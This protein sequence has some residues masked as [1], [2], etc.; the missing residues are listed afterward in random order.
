VRWVSKFTLLFLVLPLTVCLAQD[1]P[2]TRDLT[3]HTFPETE[4]YLETP[5]GLKRVGESGSRFSVK[6]EKSVNSSGKVTGYQGGFLILRATGHVDYRMS[7]SAQDWNQPRLPRTGAYLL[8]PSSP[9]TELPETVEITINTFPETG[10]FLITEEGEKEVGKSGKAFSMKPPV[11]LN[12]ASNAY[13]YVPGM[14]ILRAP[15]HADYR[16]SVSTEDWKEPTLPRSGNYNLT[17]DSL[18]VAI[19]DYIQAYPYLAALALLSVFGLLAFFVVPWSVLRLRRVAKSMDSMTEQLNSEGDPLVGKSLGKY[20]VN[21]RLG[22]GG[23]GTVYR[24]SDDIGDYAAK[25]IY[26]DK[27]DTQEL[28]RFRREFRLLSQMQHPVFPRAYDYREEEGRAFAVMELI[29]GE[30]LR[31]RVKPEGLPWA[32]VRDW[33]RSLLEGL[34]C[35]HQEGVVHRDLKPENLMLADDQIRILDFGLARQGSGPAITRTGQAFG[36]PKYIAPEQLFATGTETE[37]RS[38]LYSLGIIAYELITGTTPF[39]ADDPKVLVVMHLNQEPEPID[40]ALY[41][42]PPGVN[43]FVMTL[44]QKN[45]AN[46]YLDA[47]S[48]LRTLKNI[49]EP[50]VQED[51]MAVQMPEMD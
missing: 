2:D 4:I 5:A 33:L 46:R 1:F 45:P 39:E 9:P 25:V 6:P 48:A 38:D 44:L 14:L 51:T 28:A 16:M 7:V 20:R 40:E 17:P 35:A 42:L 50:V 27:T 32:T 29:N 43:E 49:D 21:E 23:V 8:S 26:L 31:K 15:D 10:I 19:R 24:V 11:A 18:V 12:R 41:G 22:S 30:T 36:T 3:I 34:A 47:R 37:P 13:E